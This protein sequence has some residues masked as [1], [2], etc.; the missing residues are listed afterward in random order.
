MV[1]G[2]DEKAGDFF[3]LPP[4]G[5]VCGARG[6]YGDAFSFERKKKKSQ[7]FEKKSQRGRR[8]EGGTTKR[9]LCTE[10]KEICKRRFPFDGHGDRYASSSSMM[11]LHKRARAMMGPTRAERDPMSSSSSFDGRTEKKKEK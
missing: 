7:T 1:I 8:H 5:A 3:S 6:I 2:G 10:E 9:F 4:P 11:T